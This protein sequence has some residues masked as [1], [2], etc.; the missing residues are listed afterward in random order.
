MSFKGWLKMEITKKKKGMTDF[1][2]CK[3]NNAYCRKFT[4]QEYSK[5]QK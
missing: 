2:E 5:N 1:P 4:K 3:N